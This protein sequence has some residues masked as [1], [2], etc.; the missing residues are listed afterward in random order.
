[1]NLALSTGSLSNCVE[2]A[3][4]WY[5]PQKYLSPVYFHISDAIG[6][7]L[8]HFDFGVTSFGKAIGGKTSFLYLHFY[9]GVLTTLLFFFNFF[10]QNS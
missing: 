4:G 9:S 8:Q 1:M 2:I 7:A 6:Y 10:P 3:T 5:K